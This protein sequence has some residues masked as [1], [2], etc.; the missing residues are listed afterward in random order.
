MLFIK[1][2]QFSCHHVK[3]LS[4]LLLF[5]LPLHVTCVGGGTS[6]FRT[7]IRASCDVEHPVATTTARTRALCS[8]ADIISAPCGSLIF[9]APNCGRARALTSLTNVARQP[10]PAVNNFYGHRMYAQRNVNVTHIIFELSAA[11]FVDPSPVIF[12]ENIVSRLLRLRFPVPY[13]A[14]VFNELD[15]G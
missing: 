14:Y 1:H 10:S 5:D 15:S 2:N 12:I 11:K 6:A 7:R 4:R 3:S 8:A 13:N 9:S